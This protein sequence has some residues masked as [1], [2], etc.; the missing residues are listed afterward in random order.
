M[1]WDAS[2]RPSTTISQTAMVRFVDDLEFCAP[3]HAATMLAGFDMLRQEV[4][5]TDVTLMAGGQAFPCQRAVLALCSPYFRAMFSGE[6]LEVKATSVELPA[7]EPATLAMLLDF[8]YTGRLTINQDNVEAI[9]EAAGHL[10]FTVVRQVCV[11]YLLQQI[12]PANCLGILEF[13]QRQG[14]L[15]LAARAQAFLL[16][17]LLAVA[18]EDEFLQLPAS[19]L[20]GLL[21]SSSLRTRGGRRLVEAALIWAKAPVRQVELSE[22]NFGRSDYTDHSDC[23]LVESCSVERSGNDTIKGEVIVA[24]C[25]TQ[26]D[27]VE[28]DGTSHTKMS[29]CDEDDDKRTQPSKNGGT[30]E[31]NLGNSN[32]EWNQSVD[33]E[34]L[35]TLASILRGAHLPSIPTGDVQALVA[36][37]EL[38]RASPECCRLL[39]DQVK[40]S[41]ACREGSDIVREVLVVVG[42]RAM[43]DGEGEIGAGRTRPHN[44]A[45]YE[46]KADEWHVLPDFPE[47]DKWGFAVTALNDSV[48]VTGGSRGSTEN[49]WSTKQTWCLNPAKGCWYPV[50]PM[51]R[52]RTNHAATALNGEM[53]SVGGSISDMVEVERYNPY[54]DSWCLVSPTIKYVSN[55]TATGCSG[56]LYII[57]SCALKYTALAL[58]CY[59]PITDFWAVISS[60][61]LPRYL[62]SPRS[63]SQHGLIYLIAD[64]TK[65]VYAYDP[66]VNMWQKVQLLHKLH[67]N[68]GMAVLGRRLF[69]TGGYWQGLEGHYR[70]MMEAYDCAK[71]IWTLL[72]P[73]P[74]T[75]FYHDSCAVYLD[76]GKWMELF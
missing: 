22:S 41:E 64:N 46:P 26:G 33:G 13:A 2:V 37:D 65:K 53:Y 57:G 73:L 25:S 56:R 18:K 51:L 28:C 11:R 10:Q 15:E 1:D 36:A 21:D 3:S 48:Y 58:Q 70:V 19:Q 63:A 39:E 75:W 52:S 61:F 20:V 5:F 62:S 31:G 71:D 55:F 14:L 30:V 16:E 59:N 60:P 23:A 38:L 40:Q 9:T 45:F 27:A 66:D 42:G 76:T 17:H 12:E 44:T 34:L 50:A 35:T 32:T 67:E 7:V 6:F 69:A 49:S 24:G 8:A 43:E 68:G 54:D 4:A 47:Y 29:H 74:R 72:G